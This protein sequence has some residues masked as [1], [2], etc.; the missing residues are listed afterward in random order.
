[1]HDENMTHEPSIDSSK[2]TELVTRIE[3]LEATIGAIQQR[4]DR[5]ENE[6]ESL[7]KVTVEP[8]AELEQTLD[9][10]RQAMDAR[11]TEIVASS[12]TIDP[13]NP[14]LLAIMAQVL[15]YVDRRDAAI[16]NEL[17]AKTDALKAVLVRS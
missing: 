14:A 2:I 5:C 17:R 7:L 11:I 13:E 12:T 1:M 15:D 6:H 8:L 10:T 16:L 4:Q 3:V 9:L